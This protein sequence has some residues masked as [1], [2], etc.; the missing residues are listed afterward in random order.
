MQLLR[1]HL[2]EQQEKNPLAINWMDILSCIRKYV[3]LL[4]P[5]S[6]YISS[7]CLFSKQI[8][9]IKSGETYKQFI[10]QKYMHFLT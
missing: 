2:H 8:Y 10:S 1:G 3:Y 5:F 7:K 6:C 4:A 9:Y